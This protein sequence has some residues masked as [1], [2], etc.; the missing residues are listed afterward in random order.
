[1]KHYL[2][3][4]KKK[5]FDKKKTFLSTCILSVFKSYHSVQLFYFSSY[6]F[7]LLQ[8]ISI[9]YRVSF[10]ENHTF[11]VCEFISLCLFLSCHLSIAVLSDSIVLGSH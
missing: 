5:N 10:N 7:S 2:T 8:V 4:A 11:I 9:G 6:L 3:F 1:M